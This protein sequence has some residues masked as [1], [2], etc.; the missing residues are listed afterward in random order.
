MRGWTR[1]Q[2]DRVIVQY[3]L[4]VIDWVSIRGFGRSRL[5]QDLVIHMR[6]ENL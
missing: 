4:G 2:F 1:H 3:S 6:K 5:K